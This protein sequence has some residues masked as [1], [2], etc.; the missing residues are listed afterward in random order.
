M[1]K[2]RGGGEFGI[3]FKIF[4]SG[5]REGKSMGGGGG[6]GWGGGGGELW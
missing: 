1:M 4:R 5:G 2:R 3:F 6:G